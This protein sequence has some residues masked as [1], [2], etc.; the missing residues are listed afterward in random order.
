MLSICKQ[1]SNTEGQQEEG[2]KIDICGLH[3]GSAALFAARLQDIQKQTLC[4]IVPAD[5]L[6][7]SLARDIRLFTD[8]PVFIYPAFEIA[9][10]AQ[11]APDPITV[12]TRLSTLYFL[13]ERR[14][15]CI[16]LSSAEAVM[17]RILPQQVLS[18]NC[19]LVMAGEETDRDGLIASLTGAGYQPCELVRQPGDLAVRGG[20]IDLFPPSSSMLEWGGME[21]P[22]P[23]RLDFFGDT[24]ES[25]RVFDP[26]TQRSEE[27]LEEAVLLPASD[28]LFPASSAV[29]KWHEELYAAAESRQVV[30]QLKE[31]MRFPGIEFLLPLIYQNPGPQTLFDYLPAD[32]PCIL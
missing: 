17:R 15:P 16:V 31:R 23:L 32:C 4:C 26:L 30:Q 12:A 8:V 25:I 11:L 9:P 1:L 10:Y 6:L 2:K 28:I 27:E 18:G 22:R 13:Q 3:G 24:V 29:E 19:E 14:G 7:E 5:D 21:G 20:I